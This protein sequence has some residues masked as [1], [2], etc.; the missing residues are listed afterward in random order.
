[1]PELLKQ[2]NWV[3]AVFLFLFIGTVYRGTRTGVGAQ[4]LSLGGWTAILYIAVRYHLLVSEAIFGFMLQGWSKPLSFSA[5]AVLGF[6]VLKFLE[7]VFSVVL[8][9]ELSIF[10][11]IGGAVVSSLRAFML[12]GM[13]G[14][15]LL[16]TPVD[17]LWYSASKASRTCVFFIKFDAVVYR[18][19]GG[20][21]ASEDEGDPGRGLFDSLL[22]EERSY[23]AVRSG[24]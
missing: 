23:N 4:L 2:L 10:E 1:M 8:G 16:M 17:Y 3:D 22:S 24:R 14:I 18:S 13:I 11:R 9:S 21:I 19:I 7:R 15:F 12:F 6:V 5:I 20:L